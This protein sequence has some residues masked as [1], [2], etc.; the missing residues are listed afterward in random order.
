MDERPETGST[1]TA[2]T[3][4]TSES[5]PAVSPG[6]SVSELLKIASLR[7][8]TAVRQAAFR[9]ARRRTRSRRSKAAASSFSLLLLGGI[10]VPAIAFAATGGAP[11]KT[12][13]TTS[14]APPPGPELAAFD[15]RPH[16]FGGDWAAGALAAP[17]APAPSAPAPAPPTT[18][19][20]AA[21]RPAPATTATAQVVTA[22]GRYLGT[23]VVTCYDLQG[24]TASGAETSTETV[25]VDPRVIPLGSR[26]NIAG[27]GERIAQ[28]TGGAIKGDR[29]DIWE[30]TYAQCAAW[31]VESR[32]VWLG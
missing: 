23:F 7:R 9:A 20:P 1:D 5:T 24:R 2:A 12:T 28:D 16:P 22:Q 19:P 27:V 17:A 13:P 14:S 15:A 31:G 25:A 18:A 4:A 32:Q 26:V 11:N 30:P 21:P 10:A 6:S 29:L 8:G 3:S